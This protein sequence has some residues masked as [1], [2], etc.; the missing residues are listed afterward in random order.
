M[1][2]IYI[3]YH[4]KRV[5]VALV[6]N[7]EVVE[8]Y[9]E[10]S[11]MPKLVGNIYKGKVV[12]VLSSMKAAFVNIGLERNAFLH[13]GETLVDPKDIKQSV[14]TGSLNVSPGDVIMCQVVKDHF[15]TKGVRISQNVSIPGRLLVIMPYVNFVGISHKIEDEDERK[16]LEQLVSSHQPQN[17]GF[18]VRT[19]AA[20]ASD[21]EILA[22]MDKLVSKWKNILSSFQRAPVCTTVYE[23]GD[24]IFRTIRD[25]L[26]D[27]V[28]D[29]FVNNENVYRDLAEKL[30]S[31]YPNKKIL[32]YYPGEDNMFVHYGFQ[33]Q[34]DGLLKRKVVMKNGTY[35]VIDRTEALTVIDV[36]TGKFVGNTDLEQT[37]FETNM[38]ATAEIA[39]QLRLRNIGGIVVIDFID[40]A[41]EE[42]RKA[43]VE[44]LGKHLAKDRIHTSQPVMTN[45]GLVELTRKKTRSMI[46]AVM[47]R[48]C[49]YCHGDGYVF[50]EELVILNLRD[51][52][53]EHFQKS[54]ATS[55]IVHIH[56]DVFAKVF[57][58]RYLSKECQSAWKGKRIYLIP[59]STIHAEAF[60]I[61]ED[62]SKILTLP[63]SAK[64]LY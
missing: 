55:V 8:F 14:G 4:P 28:D 1:K 40:M 49:P 45:L 10:R 44:E 13:V 3:D 20:K 36:N 5:K 51:A 50:S 12:N 25:F 17:I 30:Q 11:S 42:H 60:T 39:K 58:L 35:L 24:L 2:R 37:V 21:E 43:V 16:R 7:G 6:E 59:D 32:K 47:L 52:L 19:E 64:M 46:D 38:V 15:G 27:D 31:L 54:S 62:N 26:S 34:I 18:I 9:I 29:I 23:E 33:K 56:P 53:F 57:A 63:S 22:E 61:K 41:D 48:E